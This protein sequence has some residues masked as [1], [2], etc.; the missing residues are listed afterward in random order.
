MTTYIAKTTDGV[1]GICVLSLTEAEMVELT[2]KLVQYG[3]VISESRGD[4][5]KVIIRVNEE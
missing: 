5:T 2:V 1:S 3:Y 4:V